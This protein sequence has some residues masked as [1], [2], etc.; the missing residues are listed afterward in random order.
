[1]NKIISLVLFLLI[2]SS[3]LGQAIGTVDKKTKE[4]YIPGNLKIEFRVFGYQFAND[5]TRKMICFSSHVG[6]VRANYNQCPLGSY[7]DTGKMKPEDKILY[8]G[9][10]GSFA[11]MSFVSGDGKK[12]VFY[13]PKSS[14]TMK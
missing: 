6:D 12:T 10:T 5:A 14:F 11:K 1:M 4:F 7:F 8:L 9:P 13:L 2:A 3:V